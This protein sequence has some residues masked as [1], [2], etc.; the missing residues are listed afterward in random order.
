MK[1]GRVTVTEYIHAPD[2]G[3]ETEALDVGEAADIAAPIL[4][5][6]PALVRFAPGTVVPS[7]DDGDLAA[8]V[9]HDP[10]TGI[11]MS[12]SG[13]EGLEY[14][15]KFAPASEYMIAIVDKVNGT[16]KVVEAAG[17]VLLSRVVALH[18]PATGED[19]SED[20][21]TYREKRGD[22]LGEFGGK[23]AKDRQAKM[24]RNAITDERI[25]AT[26]AAQ[27]DGVIEAHKQAKAAAGPGTTSVL[28]PPH[29]ADA[30][31]VREA[32]PL[33]GLMSP[34]E[35]SHMDSV[36]KALELDYRGAVTGANPGWSDICWSLMLQSH[37]ASS[38]EAVADPVADQ[39]RRLIAAI[40]LH[41]LFSLA[42]L[43]ERRI[44]DRERKTL[45]R[46]TDAPEEVVNALLLRFTEK[47]DGRPDRCRTETSNNRLIDYAVVLWLT[48][49]NFV[50]TAGNS[51]AEKVSAAL[52][53]PRPQ[54]LLRCKYVGCKLKRPGKA[55][56]PSDTSQELRIILSA[57]LDFPPF[58]TVRNTKR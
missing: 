19:L 55:K 24:E 44:G 42:K 32:Y 26:A 23:R 16:A 56:V 21:R 57:P 29:K 34:L 40:Y 12:V 31:D 38:S 41:Y 45:L 18:A 53:V 58:R 3:E 10:D 43:P 48:A 13:E 30:L 6:H 50:I 39:Q 33:L 11:R 54:L 28:V 17:E 37:E 20:K 9:E 1:R 7:E 5:G 22:L 14:A 27:L 4:A 35:Y 15:G 52:N 49:S 36:A 47:R 51:E 25:S 2:G 46:A 8:R